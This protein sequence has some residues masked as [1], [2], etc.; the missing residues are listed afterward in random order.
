MLT[1]EVAA[2]YA[3]ARPPGHHC[4]P[5]SAMGFCLLANIPIA[6]EAARADLGPMKVA[7]VDWDV[8]H[9]NGTQHIYYHR[10]DTLTLSLHQEN[11]FLPFQGL[12]SEAGSGAGLGA[13]LN[14]PLLP[15]GGHHS[16]LDA[17]DLLVATAV[18]K[19][20]PDLIVVACGLDANGYDPMA[21][22]LAHSGT[23]RAL[24]AR[25]KALA[26][27]LCRGRLVMAHEGG[28]S[29]AYVPFCALAVVEELSGHST[30][31]VD[32]FRQ[33]LEENQPAADMVAFQRA[34]LEAQVRR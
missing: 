9:G 21:R 29:E 6:L 14:I 23:F 4:L 17:F 25:I 12:V 33:F 15:G 1:G 3:L 7:V 2:A 32:P 19:F 5:D 13:N 11:C 18:R 30:E 26:A 10:A 22:M 20:A 16:Y 31:V 28:Y 34:R 8:H 24:T 27:D